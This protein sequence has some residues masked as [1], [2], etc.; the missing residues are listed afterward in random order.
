MD[1]IRC[2]PNYT[3][4]LILMLALV[5]LISA[6][7][8]FAVKKKSGVKKT[9]TLHSKAL[10]KPD[11]KNEAADLPFADIINE[12]LGVPYRRGGTGRNGFDC[13]GLS[14]R[15]YLDVFEIDLPHNSKEQSMLDIFDKVP[16]NRQHFESRDLLFFQNKKKRI[17]HVGIYLEDGKFLHATPRGGVIISSL[18]ET[19]WK[20][21]LVASRRVKETVLEKSAS[22]RGV[23]SG[24]NRMDDVKINEIAMGYSADIN[25]NLNFGVETYY[26]SLFAEQD[27]SAEDASGRQLVSI[28]SWQG[29]R[30][31]TQ[32]RPT[33]WLRITPSLGMLRG[34]VS[35]ANGDGKW[36]E[37]GLVTRISPLSSR[38]SL[39]FS[40]HSLLNERY[41]SVFDNSFDT[42]IGLQFRYRVSESLRF[43]VMGNWE[44]N[45]LMDDPESVEIGRDQMS[46]NVDISY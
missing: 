37:Y 4:F 42:D 27:Y 9:K 13:S 24:K 19:Y 43:S 31:S 32:Y 1:H 41:F 30:A 8:C 18:D 36:Q 5:H 22:R 3:K 40:M 12:Y 15:F 17:N 39:A 45:D 16:L 38:W 33:G 7:P 25:R 34:P 6:P 10:T 20:H 26:S 2:C 35:P 11:L 44:A 23:S 46:F 29:L 21:S 14:R 28:G